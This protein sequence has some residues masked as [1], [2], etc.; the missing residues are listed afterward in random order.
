MHAGLKYHMPSFG[1]GL[2][3][4]HGHIRVAQQTI[5][6]LVPG[7]CQGNA[8]AGGDNDFAAVQA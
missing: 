6:R 1:R 5:R 3:S 8:H 7:R 4:V 2:G